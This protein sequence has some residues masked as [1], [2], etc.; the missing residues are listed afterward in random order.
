MLQRHNEDLFG[1]DSNES[2]DF[3]DEENNQGAGRKKDSD[4]HAVY[5]LEPIPMILT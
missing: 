1:E 5:K 3:F 2:Y 4:K